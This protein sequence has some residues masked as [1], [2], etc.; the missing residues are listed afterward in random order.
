[1][2]IQLSKNSIFGYAFSSDHFIEEIE[3]L[4]IIMDEY[5]K[6]NKFDPLKI[7]DSLIENDERFKRI[8]NSDK[9]KNYDYKIVMIDDHDIISFNIIKSSSIIVKGVC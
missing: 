1:M 4:K 6:I 3:M 9:F 8:P 5:C 7:V 2:N